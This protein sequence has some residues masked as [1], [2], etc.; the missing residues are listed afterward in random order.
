MQSCLPSLIFA[1]YSGP[2]QAAA[3]KQKAIE[4][5]QASLDAAREAADDAVNTAAAEVPALKRK[6]KEYEEVIEQ[7]NARITR[8]ERVRLTHDQVEKLSAMKHNARKKAA[9]NKELSAT[10]KE[11]RQRL[12]ATERRAQAGRRT[13]EAGGAEVSNQAAALALANERIEE[14]QGVKSSLMQR[15]QSY[16]KRVYELERQQM[17]VRAAIE[18]AGV[19]APEGCDLSDAILEIVSRAAGADDAS[20]VSGFSSSEATASASHQAEL[21]EAK[22]ALRREEAERLTVQEQMRAGVSKYRALEATVVAARQQLAAAAADKRETMNTAL[23]MKEKDHD[24]QLKYLQVDT[25]F[26]NVLRLTRSSCVSGGLLLFHS[27]FIVNI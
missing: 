17:R 6:V 15:G 21:Q 7:R 4:E 23:K 9:E 22:A 26:I 14:L 25:L 19:V 10:I 13:A 8:L 11:L 1:A 5:L 16:G 20:V 12:T 2:P 18:K 24:R 27:A 3:V